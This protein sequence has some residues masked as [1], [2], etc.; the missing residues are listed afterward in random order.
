MSR[1]LTLLIIAL[2]IVCLQCKD[3]ASNPPG[4]AGFSLEVTVKDIS[5]NPVPGLQVSAYN[6]SD[7]PSSSAHARPFRTPHSTNSIT[8]FMFDSKEAGKFRLAILNLDNQLIDGF[9]GDVFQGSRTYNWSTD[10][11]PSSV[12]RAALTLAD[13]SFRARRFQDTILFAIDQSGDP[14]KNILGYTDSNGEVKTGK[15]WLFPYLYNLGT[16]TQTNEDGPQPIGTFSYT[17]RVAIVMTDTL[18]HLSLADTVTLTSERQNPVTVLWNPVTAVHAVPDNRNG[19]ATSVKRDYLR[20]D[21]NCDSVAYQVSDATAYLNFFLEGLSAFDDPDCSIQGSDV[22]ADNASP[23]LADFVYLVR[24]ILGESQPLPKPSAAIPIR[25]I[26]IGVFDSLGDSYLTNLT[27]DSLGA[28]DLGIM[29]SVT[30]VLLNPGM[31]MQYR[32]ELGNT[33]IVIYPPYTGVLH[34]YGFG[35]GP[36]LKFEGIIDPSIFAAYAATYDGAP[37]FVNWI[38]SKDR[39]YQNFPNPFN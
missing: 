29:G 24:V 11:L 1:K 18:A 31:A 28:I 17:D 7:L 27:G 13:S 15:S 26:E 37:A 20:G 6:I 38:P 8:S 12:Y 16:L 5:N 4:D 34:S 9:E 23:D 19:I 32:P 14:S 10:S 39:L 3:K 36:F 30:P 22:N 21:L 25:H 2:T 35:A 33:R